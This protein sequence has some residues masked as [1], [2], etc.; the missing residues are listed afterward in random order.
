MQYV[1]PLLLLTVF[2]PF[3]P[4][5]ASSDLR[6]AQSQTSVG[7]LIGPPQSTAKLLKD[8]FAPQPGYTQGPVLG[9]EVASR[10]VLETALRA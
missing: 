5:L 10:R 9:F 4:P 8:V 6:S 7:I 3:F 2:P 1:F